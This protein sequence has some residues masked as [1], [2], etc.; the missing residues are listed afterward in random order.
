M[1]ILAGP[2]S[3]IEHRVKGSRFIARALP[4]TDRPEVDR[5]LAGLRG[6]FPDASHICYAYRLAGV[7]EQPVE[8]ST[9][10]GE[11]GR[12]AGVPILNTLRRRQLVDCLAW[13]VRYFGGTKLGIPGLIA[14]YG[15]A[16]E[17]ALADAQTVPWV[18]LAVRRLLIPYTLVD[19]VKA[20]LLKVGG[21]LLDEEY[22]LYVVLLT[23]LPAV[24]LD[25]FLRQV[26][27]WGGGTIGIE[28]QN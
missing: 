6:R 12:S 10:D 19:R 3:T 15:R 9:D 2:S 25:E 13:V 27:D 4:V 11:P 5:V 18:T 21:K 1:Y 7:S 20:A 14:A 24:E 28:E 23:Q 8:F 17:M 16:V 26:Q 22:G